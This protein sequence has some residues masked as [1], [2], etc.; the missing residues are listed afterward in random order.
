[1]SKLR[2]IPLLTLLALL[3]ACALLPDQ[4]DPTKDWS[5]D[6]F[7]TEAKDSQ[8]NGD[9]QTALD[10]LQKL[11]ARY[12]F[13]RYAMQA[14]LDTAYIHYRND[15]PESAISAADRFIKLHPQSNY[16]AYAYYLKGIVNFTRN[17]GFLDDIFPTDPS[18]RDPGATLNAF[19]DFA[20][21]VRRFPDSK[22]AVDAR[23][24][25][26]YLRNNMAKHEIHV[27]DY[28]MRRGAY[29]AAAN[30]ANKVV[31]SYQRSTSIKDALEIMVEA[32]TKL[33]MTDL[34]ADAQRVLELN[35]SKGRFVSDELSESEWG[36]G[37]KIWNW[38]GLDKS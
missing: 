36:L 27:A 32:Y 12:P 4:M 19:H 35:M 16:V 20:E 26:I 30:R 11:E 21:L 10:Y 24:R 1:M 14:Q 2:L 6:K 38:F 15:E 9:Y 7:Y 28:Y 29:L 34:A 5:A 25:M 33:G 37:R 13:G 31:E 23:K 17:S 3:S 18:Q 22:Y 8:S